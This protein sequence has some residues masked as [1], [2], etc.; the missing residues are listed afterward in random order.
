MNDWEVFCLVQ[1]EAGRKEDWP[2]AL[3]VVLGWQDGFLARQEAEAELAGL[4]EN[5]A[6]MLNKIQGGEIL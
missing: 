5:P 2:R 3:D 1:D 6:A 4:V